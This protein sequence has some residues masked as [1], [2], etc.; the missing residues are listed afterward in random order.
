[1]QDKTNIS[2][3]SSEIAGLWQNYISNSVALCML[4]HFINTVEDADVKPH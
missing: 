3:A 2:L 1:M 4:K